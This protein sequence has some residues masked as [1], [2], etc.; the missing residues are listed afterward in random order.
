MKVIKVLA[1]ALVLVLCVAAV[2][3]KDSEAATEYCW[4]LTDGTAGVYSYMKLGVMDFGGGNYTLAGLKVQVYT[5]YPYAVNKQLVNGSMALTSSTT[6][7]AGLNVTDISPY[8]N[9]A[10]GPGLN[11]TDMH[12]TISPTTFSGTYYRTTTITSSTGAT[13]ET[14]NNGIATFTTCQ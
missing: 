1:V 13:T 5:V 14:V 2:N 7:E 12:M 8:S 6:I 4:L 3:T 11:T 9:V 10:A